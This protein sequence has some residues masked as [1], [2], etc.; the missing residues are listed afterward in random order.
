[1]R[2]RDR[3]RQFGFAGFFSITGQLVTR[4]IDATWQIKPLRDE[5]DVWPE[6]YSR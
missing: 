3:F 2:L 1:M 4:L 5:R 6:G